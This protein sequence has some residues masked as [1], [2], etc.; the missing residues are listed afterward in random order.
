MAKATGDADIRPDEQAEPALSAIPARSS[1][2]IWV[3]AGTPGIA[4]AEVLGRRGAVLPK[5]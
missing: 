3:D 4:I 2:M 1:A 5:M